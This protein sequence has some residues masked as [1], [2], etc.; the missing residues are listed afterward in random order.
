LE[1]VDRRPEVAAP[2]EW[3]ARQPDAGPVMEFPVR[4]TPRK[5]TLAMYWSTV[6][7]KPLVQG[8]SGFVPRLHD[9]VFEPFT[10][11][12]RRPDGTVVREVSYV[13]AGNVGIL[14]DLGVRYLVF[15]REGYKRA[16]WP[17]VVA[18]LEGTGAA[19]LGGDFGETVVYRLRPRSAP[20]PAPTLILVAPSLATPQ[21]YWEPA[22]VVRN[23][24]A[25][26]ALLAIRRPLKL[27]TVWRDERGR[28]VRRDVGLLNLYATVPPGDTICSI[29]YC[30]VGPDFRVSPAMLARDLGR[31]PLAP[32]APGHYTVELAVTGELTATR[33]LDVEVAPAPPTAAEDGP[34]IELTAA[35]AIARAPDDAAVT[36]VLDWLV[37]RPPAGEYTL[38]ARLVDEDGR[39][40]GQRDAPLGWPTHTTA[41]WSPGERFSLPWRIPLQSGPPPGQY[42]LHLAVYR[43][44]AAGTEPVPVRWPD[45]DAVEYAVG[46]RQ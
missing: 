42:R 3:L 4:E 46:G 44:T 1:D 34:E 14:Q 10:G 18:N 2:Y 43:R 8:Q 13:H 7:W 15:H 20:P 32:A 45:G 9:S 38:S 33:T 29:R 11:D 19:E 5:T 39:V 28:E 40:W 31:A 37:R 6:H 30:P 25:Q 16:D 24:R 23:P 27:T 21:D 12:L 26:P 36:F 22:L 17:T 41:A 35:P